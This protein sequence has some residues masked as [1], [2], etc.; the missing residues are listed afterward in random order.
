MDR[1][2]LASIRVLPS[3]ARNDIVLPMD[4]TPEPELMNELEQARAYAHADFEEPHE[5]FVA[6][7]TE[8]FPNTLPT[9]VYLDL[10]CGPADIAI[11]FARAHADVHVHGVDGAPRMLDLGR[12]AITAAG[13]DARVQLF[14]KLLPAKELPQQHYDGV[15]SNSLLHHLHEPQVFWNTIRECTAPGAPVFVMDLHRPETPGVAEQ[16]VAE[17]SGDEPEILRRDFYNSLLAAF[18]VDEVEAQLAEASIDWLQLRQITDR[19]FL[20]WGFASE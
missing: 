12:E 15:I 17:Y 8:C 2:E 7:F 4:R 6:Q 3:W 16:L 9:G 5:Q 1:V 13:L 20:A 14:E 10:G 18:R 19:H 11:R